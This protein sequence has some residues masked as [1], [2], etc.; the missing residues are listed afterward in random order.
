VWRLAQS[1]LAQL[2]VAFHGWRRG[3]GA[4]LESSFPHGPMG[5]DPPVESGVVDAVR[6]DTSFADDVAGSA[7]LAH[8]P[9]EFTVDLGERCAVRVG[10]D[11]RRIGHVRQRYGPLAV[12]SARWSQTFV[13]SL[14]RP[15]RV[16]R[17]GPRGGLRRGASMFKNG[18]RRSTLVGVSSW[19]AAVIILF[20]AGKIH[21]PV[22]KGVLLVLV[23]TCVVVA[24]VGLAKSLLETRPRQ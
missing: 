2:D 8:E 3:G 18:I 21:Q 11:R 9:G 20:I 7:V 23:V 13:G 4:D 10:P 1:V 15:G 19:I 22:I 16:D 6:S 5:S 12:I 14:A 17:R 24:V